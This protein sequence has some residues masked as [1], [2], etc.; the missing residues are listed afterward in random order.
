MQ[1]ESV[2]LARLLPEQCVVVEARSDAWWSSGLLKE[3]QPFVA[4]AVEKRR[5]E[6]TAGRNCARTALIRLGLPPVPIGVGEHRQPLFP[7]IVSGSITHTRDYCAAAV[8]RTG[9]VR[10]IGIDAESNAPLDESVARRVLSPDELRRVRSRRRVGCCDD[11]LLFSMKEAFFKA[12]FPVCRRHV[13]FDEVDIHLLPAGDSCDVGVL[14][15]DLAA[16]LQD[17][18]IEAR[19]RFDAERVY[20]AVTLWERRLPASGRQSD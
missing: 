8:V 10:A 4:H 17:F 2:A 9:S 1:T 18:D 20:S 6:F 11:V 5:R 12:V 14:A 19:C 13:D 16:L 15:P 7:A 3:E